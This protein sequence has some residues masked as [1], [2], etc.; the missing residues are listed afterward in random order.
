M[1]PFVTPGGDTNHIPSTSKDY[2]KGND[3][4]YGLTQDPEEAMENQYLYRASAI[5]TE[6]RGGIVTGDDIQPS[7]PFSAPPEFQ[8]QPGRWTPEHFF[9]ASIAGCFVSTF[10]GMA[11]FS[12]FD[13]LSLE[14]EVE[15]LIQK[16]EGGWRFTQVTLRPRLRIA[17]TKEH[18]RAIRLLEKAEKTCLVTRSL[19]SR[20]VFEPEI[21]VEE[22]AYESQ[23]L[24]DSF[25]VT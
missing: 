2:R 20:I 6:L 9:V 13:Y 16:D 12:K 11:H 25:P 23:K 21:L 15:G 7:I 3:Q 18:E 22:E 14:L 10:S 1:V 4:E 17:P 5:S 24:E 8:G 19:A